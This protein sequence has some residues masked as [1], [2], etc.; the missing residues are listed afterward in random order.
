[1]EERLASAGEGEID[2]ETSENN[3]C[4]SQHESSITSK[5]EIASD[6]LIQDEIGHKKGDNSSESS[7][8]ECESMVLGNGMKTSISSDTGQENKES[9]EATIEEQKRTTQEQPEAECASSNHGKSENCE[10]LPFYNQIDDSSDF[11]SRLI[12]ESIPEPSTTGYDEDISSQSCN[13]KEKSS[14]VLEGGSHRSPDRQ[15]KVEYRKIKSEVTGEGETSESEGENDTESDKKESDKKQETTNKE[16]VDSQETWIDMLGNG[17]LRKRVGD[18]R[19]FTVDVWGW[20]FSFNLITCYF[21]AWNTAYVQIFRP[22]KHPN[23]EVSK[24]YSKT[25]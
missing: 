6:K 11:E 8:K 19:Y 23:R 13:G 3:H 22:L 20:I 2:R 16:N 4:D 18:S 17:L 9:N 15:S 12:Q 7:K 10:K 14:G 1:M 21:R 24:I 25:S 5:D